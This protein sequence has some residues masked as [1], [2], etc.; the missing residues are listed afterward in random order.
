MKWKAARL[1][2]RWWWPFL[3]PFAVGAGG[4]FFLNFAAYPAIRLLSWLRCVHW[5][6]SSWPALWMWFLRHLSLPVAVR[7]RRL[8][9]RGSRRLLQWCVLLRGT[10][11][12]FSNRCDAS[13]GG[14][15]LT[16]P[17][18]FIWWYRVYFHGHR[19]ASETLGYLSWYSK[20][21]TPLCG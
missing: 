2:Q 21:E 6:G 3:A 7:I 1:R 12:T 14:N 16:I 10:V 4:V 15:M 17:L 13:Q 19:K 11:F 5:R 20:T 18:W 8:W 9:R